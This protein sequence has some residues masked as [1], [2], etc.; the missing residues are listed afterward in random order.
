VSIFGV[1]HDRPLRADGHL[2]SFGRAAEWLN[3]AQLS[4]PDLVVRSSSSTSGRYEESDQVIQR[5]LGIQRDFVSINAVGVAPEA[6]SA[7]IGLLG[8]WGTR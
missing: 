3:S 6:D 4:P 7:F 8:L 1:H 5:L 2:P